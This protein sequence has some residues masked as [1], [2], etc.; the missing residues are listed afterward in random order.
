MRVVIAR[1]RRS[2]TPHVC[3]AFTRPPHSFA[4]A[5]QLFRLGENIALENLDELRFLG[6][7]RIWDVMVD[8]DR[9]KARDCERVE[10]ETRRQVIH[11]VRHG[12]I[13]NSP[14]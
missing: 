11:F 3:D 13:S 14:G 5:Q 7:C 9:S 6:G 1:D 10:V 4:F 12:E 2:T 8:E